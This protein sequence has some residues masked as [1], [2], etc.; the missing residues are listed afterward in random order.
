VAALLGS[1]LLLLLVLPHP[2]GWL[3]LNVSAFAAV[4]VLSTIAI[5]I[6]VLVSRTEHAHQEAVAATQARDTFFSLAAHELRTPLTAYM[7]LMELVHW[8]VQRLAAWVRQRHLEVAPEVEATAD[9]LVQADVAIERQSQLV[10]ELLD[11]SRVQA[12]TLTFQ[13]A[14]CDLVAVVRE[15]VNEQQDLQPARPIRMDL[16]GQPAVVE[17]DRERMRQVVTNF[18]TNALKYAPADRPI[19]VVLTVTVD[20]VRVAVQDRGLGLSRDEQARVWDLYHRVPG[21]AVVKGSDAGLGLGLYLCR[22]IVRAHPSGQVGVDSTLG[23][24][25]SFWFSLPLAPVEP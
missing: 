11:T 3:L 15:A 4:G 6:S 24:G 18:L 1:A 13:F 22:M 17:A 19:D 10:D 14:P 23:E 7:G 20:R 5:V 16:P 8:R 9:L 2:W 21:V 25:S 12:G